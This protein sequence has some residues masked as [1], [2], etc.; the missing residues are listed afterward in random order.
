MKVTIRST[1]FLRSESLKLWEGE[2]DF[3]PR[4]GD[5]IIP[6]EAF[7]YTTVKKVLFNQIEQYAIIFV[8]PDY[9]GEWAAAIERRKQ[10]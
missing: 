3:I 10:K 9:T 6:L 4:Q 8:G 7:Y 1:A 5:K 2:T